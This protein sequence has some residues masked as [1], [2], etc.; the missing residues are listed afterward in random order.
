MVD[1]M[2]ILLKIITR[3]TIITIINYYMSHTSCNKIGHNDLLYGINQ[4]I[5]TKSKFICS[6]N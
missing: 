5:I 6:Y 1:S 4:Y 2:R 3:Q